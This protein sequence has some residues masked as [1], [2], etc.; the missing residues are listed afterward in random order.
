MPIKESLLLFRETHQN[1]TFLTPPRFRAL[2]YCYDI[3]HPG[4]QRAPRVGTVGLQNSSSLSHVR[5][6]SD[7]VF[8]V[9]FARLLTSSSRTPRT[10]TTTSP[11]MTFS[12]TSTTSSTTW[13]TTSRSSVRVHVPFVEY[14]VQFLLLVSALHMLCSISHVQPFRV[15]TSLLRTRNHVFSPISRSRS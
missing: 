8:G 4:L 12:P 15:W 13:V 5:E 1:N 14:L 2:S 3:P 9:R 6:K 11:T 7:K 10:P